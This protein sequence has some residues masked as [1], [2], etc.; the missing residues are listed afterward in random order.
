M[1]LRLL[2][3]S[4]VKRVLGV[5]LLATL[6]VAVMACDPGHGFTIINQTDQD[7]TYVW[8]RGQGVTLK[9]LEERRPSLLYISGD[10][11]NP[12]NHLFQAFDLD[13][14]LICESN[15]TEQE[16]ED[17]NWTIHIIEAEECGAPP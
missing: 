5:V 13:G 12:E 16:W 15:H 4:R 9:P 14:N 2:G 11:G 17:Q 1:T 6:L 7:A 3:R 10:R 8:N